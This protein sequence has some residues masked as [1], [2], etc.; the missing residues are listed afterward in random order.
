MSD[1]SKNILEAWAA[2]A[3]PDPTRITGLMELSELWLDQ[4]EGDKY[5]LMGHYEA[6]ASRL[7]DGHDR[8]RE[9]LEQKRPELDPSVVALLERNLAAFKQA[10]EALD[11]F[12]E[13]ASEDNKEGCWKALEAMEEAAEELRT[14]SGSITT[15]S[16]QTAIC[17]KCGSAGDEPLCPRCNIDRL[18][19]DP[20]FFDREGFEQ[21]EVSE[22]FVKASEAYHQVLAGELT[23]KGL[24]SA[25]RPL[26]FALMEAE[27]L[28]QASEHETS[29]AVQAAAGQSI[30]G[31][32][33]M[34]KVTKSRDLKD[35]NNGWVEVL[36]GG[37]KLKK[38]I[39]SRAAGA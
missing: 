27:A 24:M 36:R 13:A 4:G 9:E 35:L 15:H 8:R 23:V 33:R 20:D 34:R 25:L 39:D 1:S 2:E 32:K 31:L 17:S 22:D 29:E 6:L 14:V 10:G 16:T 12:Q 37:I 30:A 7:M 5:E 11:L 28:A 26:E 38:L 21:G 3:G 19:P 18:I